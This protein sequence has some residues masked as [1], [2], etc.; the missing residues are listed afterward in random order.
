MTKVRKFLRHRADDGGLSAAELMRQCGQKLTD[1]ALWQSFQERFHWRI[2]TYVIRTIVILRRN[3]DRDLVCDLVQD[4]YLRLLRDNGRSMSNFREETDFSVFAFLGRM[5]MCAVSDHFRSQ[6]AGK[7]TAEI[8]SIEDARRI[9]EESNVE[10]LDLTSILSWIDVARLIEADPD[11]RNA[12]RNVLIFKLHYVEGLTVRE[13]SQYPGFDL[14]EGAIE[15][16]LKNL[17]DQLRKKM[18]R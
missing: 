12:P 5:T 9:E 17:R 6:Q 1:V 2:T 15:V 8:I 14:K 13:I 18:G 7:R 16:I 11:R 3:P 4:V 10:S